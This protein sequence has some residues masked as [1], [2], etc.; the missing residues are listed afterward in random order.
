MNKN[1]WSLLFVNWSNQWILWIW[2]ELSKYVIAWAQ[3]LHL[4]YCE[5]KGSPE[6]LGEDSFRRYRNEMLQEFKRFS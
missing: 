3:M 1:K 5:L 4:N 2:S 6:K